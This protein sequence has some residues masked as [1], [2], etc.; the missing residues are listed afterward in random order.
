MCFPAIR[1][2]IICRNILYVLTVIFL[3]ACRYRTGFGMCCVRLSDILLVKVYP[4]CHVLDTVIQQP[5]RHR[6]TVTRCLFIISCCG[7]NAI[8]YIWLYPTVHVCFLYSQSITVL[9]GHLI[10]LLITFAVT[11]LASVPLQVSLHFLH[12]VFYWSR[13]VSCL[14]QSNKLKSKYMCMPTGSYNTVALYCT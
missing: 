1:N 14:G 4:I 3:L 7:C 2:K 6:H 10:A 11:K 12:F 13:F 8:L 9:V 5:H